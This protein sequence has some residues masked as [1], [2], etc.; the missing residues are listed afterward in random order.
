MYLVLL[1]PKG[2]KKSFACAT[3]Q[4]VLTGLS[5]RSKVLFLQLSKQTLTEAQGHFSF[6]DQALIL[7]TDMSKELGG[8]LHK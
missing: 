5:E 8:T 1:L 2:D 7:K 3:T 4:V 6:P